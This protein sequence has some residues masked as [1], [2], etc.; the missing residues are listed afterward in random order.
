[1]QGAGMIKVCVAAVVLVCMA[2]QAEAWGSFSCNLTPVDKERLTNAT[3]KVI[4]VIST[5]ASLCLVELP[6]DPA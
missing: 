6:Q 3:V 5:D 1:M 4:N 2:V